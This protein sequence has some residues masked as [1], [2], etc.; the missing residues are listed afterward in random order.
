MNPVAGALLL[1]LLAHGAALSGRAAETPESLREKASAVLAQLEG[2]IK[3]PGLKQPVEVLRDH[4]GV[5]H[6][7]AKNPDDL[8]CA[9]GF[10]AA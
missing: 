4:W 6:I 5:P 7:Y 2:E 3:V 8:F 10:V 9:Q 1:A